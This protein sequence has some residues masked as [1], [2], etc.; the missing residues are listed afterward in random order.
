VISSWLS[1]AT[2]PRDGSPIMLRFGQDRVCQG[3]YAGDSVAHIAGGRNIGHPWEFVDTNGGLGSFINFSRDGDGGPSQ[4]M[5]MPGDAAPQDASAPLTNDQ[6]DALID[7]IL[8]AAGSALRHYTMQ[9]SRDDM[10]QAMRDA[11]VQAA[12]GAKS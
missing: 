5:P 1:I 2:A 12:S 9:K 3:R 8:R 10:R 4:W 11:L 6:L 7:P